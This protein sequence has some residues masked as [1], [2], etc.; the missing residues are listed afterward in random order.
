M[1]LRDAIGFFLHVSS[2]KWNAGLLGI[3]Y[4]LNMRYI[5]SRE[6]ECGPSVITWTSCVMWLATSWGCLYSVS[7]LAPCRAIFHISMQF[8]WSSHS[9]PGSVSASHYSDSSS[10]PS[11]FFSFS[12]SVLLLPLLFFFNVSSLFR[13][14]QITWLSSIT[15]MIFFFWYKIVYHKKH[16]SH[17][18]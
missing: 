3:M 4:T 14:H 18:S 1:H 5:E 16:M 7:L 17:S 8:L 13:L 15:M 6:C 9:H 12:L 10:F 11:L 2:T